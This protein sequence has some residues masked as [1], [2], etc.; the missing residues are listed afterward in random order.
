MDE[1]VVSK[2]TCLKDPSKI[3]KRDEVSVPMRT[4]FILPNP[5]CQSCAAFEVRC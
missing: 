5:S 3:S 1:V 4:I 2:S